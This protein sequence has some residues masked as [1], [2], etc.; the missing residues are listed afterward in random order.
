MRHHITL[1]L[2]TLTVERV[3]NAPTIVA[4]RIGG[5]VNAPNRPAQVSIGKSSV[6]FTPL[7]E[8]TADD[9]YKGEDGGLYGGGRNELPEQLRALAVQRTSEIK[10]LDADGDPAP[11]GKIGLV[12]ISMSNATQEFSRFKQIADAC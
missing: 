1:L 10:P 5:R 12:S 7:N 9:R 2:F 3:A 6:G 4:I 8:M 11:G